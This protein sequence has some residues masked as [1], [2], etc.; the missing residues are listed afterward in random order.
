VTEGKRAAPGRATPG[1]RRAARDG[2]RPTGSTVGSPAT[3]PAAADPAAVSAAIEVDLAGHPGLLIRPPAA[4]GLYVLAH[5]AGAG[6][7]HA[8]LA[9]IAGAL[10]A[11]EVATL[12]WEFP[13]MAAGK[14][15]PDRAEVAEAAV[16]EVW[17]A[18]R[19]QLPELPAFAGGKSFGGR[20]TSR[21]HA[22]A[23]LP[24]LRGLIF[25]GFPLHPPD[26]PGVERAEHLAAASGPLLFVQ[27]DRD[28]LAGL[29]R[30][31]PVVARLGERAT[32][33]VVKAADH[34]F[35]VQVRS[36]RTRSD[37]LDEIA[38]TVASWITVRAARG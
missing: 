18:A 5:G 15:R 9:A 28:E 19:S 33:H 24:G 37:V 16:R 12:R 21:A 8:F 20:M 31:R 23:P 34:G 25:L 10:A 29:R 38:D 35:D 32:L 11:R 14:P 3:A 30:L 17:T 13:Y 2:E 7:R 26:K 6:M 27:G 4:R 1:R 22:A 36:G